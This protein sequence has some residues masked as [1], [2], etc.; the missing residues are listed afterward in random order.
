MATVLMPPACPWLYLEMKPHI[1]FLSKFNK[2]FEDCNVSKS[3]SWW[4][5]CSECCSLTTVTVWCCISVGVPSIRKDTRFRNL[6]SLLMLNQHSWCKTMSKSVMDWHWTSCLKQLFLD[7][8]CFVMQL[9]CLAIGSSIFSFC[10]GTPW[11]FIRE[12]N[13]CY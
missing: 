13:K 2:N 1:L 11:G 9:F 5:I 8:C 10:P 12:A 7:T 4:K 3:H 6:Q